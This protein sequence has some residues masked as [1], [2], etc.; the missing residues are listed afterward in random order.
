MRLRYLPPF[1]PVRINFNPGLLATALYQFMKYSIIGLLGLSCFTLVFL[2]ACSQLGEVNAQEAQAPL[3]TS[4]TA[5][6]P[7]SSE[8]AP[9]GELAELPDAVA[10]EIPEP[11]LDNLWQIVAQQ[12]QLAPQASNSA[13]WHRIE[14]QQ[15]AFLRQ[16][17]Y[18]DIISRRA[19]PYFYHVVTQVQ[20]RNMPIEIALL[21]AVE[22]GYDAFAY[23]HGR[24]AGLWQFVPPTAR[25]FGLTMD[26]WY[27]GRRDVIVATDT[28]LDYLQAL[29]KR[30]DGDWLLALA[31]YN[32][33]GG[34]VNK[35][36][37]K[38]RKAGK[39]TDYWSL[40]LPKETM[41]YVPKLLALSQLLKH[42]D[43]HQLALPHI[44]NKPVFK[45]CNTEGQIDLAL[46]A[47]LANTELENIYRLNPAFNHWATRPDGPH[48]LLIEID[49]AHGFEQAI[50][51][52][53]AS[54]RLNWHRYKVKSGD[55][56]STIAQRFNT[57]QKLIKSNNQLESNRIRIGQTLLVAKASNQLD[58]YQLSSQ[59]RLHKIQKRRPRGAKYKTLHTVK[60]GDSFWSI[61]KHYKVDHLAIP[62]W[63]GMA[64]ADAL[65][66]GKRIVIWQ[67]HQGARGEVRKVAYS[68][69]S[70]DSLARIASRF[71]VKALDIARWNGLNSKNYLQPGQQLRLYVDVTKNY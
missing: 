18:F 36:L 45:R 58:Q 67:K 62:R 49:K 2:S 48:H 16:N 41:G 68:V 54:K 69:R 25:G 22:S 52:T 53:P 63:N 35:A 26:W 55:T 37:R 47:K 51:N 60:T 9:L 39:P 42:A 27:D 44:S 29:H 57:S 23:S 70:G 61:G 34:T 3:R 20:K 8:L 7:S 15:K 19:Q 5:A 40:K 59:Q 1:A 14:Q 66:P 24:A 50:A 12:V 17:N 30:F 10:V 6:Q 38:N 11:V 71:R 33:G 64:P 43:Q 56:L 21:P 46:A 28:A 4:H 65:K 31:A 13:A 32:S